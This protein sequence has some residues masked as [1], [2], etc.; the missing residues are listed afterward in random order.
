MFVC[1]DACIHRLFLYYLTHN[2]VFVKMFIKL[3]YCL[4]KIISKDKTS[5]TFQPLSAA[6]IRASSLSAHK[7]VWSAGIVS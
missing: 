2:Y 5:L 1:N 7:R 3:E 6:V 4:T